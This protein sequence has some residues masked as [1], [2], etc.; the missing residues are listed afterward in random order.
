MAV[1]LGG[2]ERGLPHPPTSEIRGS[3]GCGASH[4]LAGHPE[5]SRTEVEKEGTA[6]NVVIACHD[7]LNTTVGVTTI[8]EKRHSSIGTRLCI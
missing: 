3:D 7:H 2:W 1:T 4:A 5:V 8:G 6:F